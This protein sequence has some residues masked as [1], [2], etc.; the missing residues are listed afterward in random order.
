MLL[1]SNSLMSSDFFDCPEHASGASTADLSRSL[2]FTGASGEMPGKK[3]PRV[4]LHLGIE[5]MGHVVEPALLLA[6]SAGFFVALCYLRECGFHAVQIEQ[7]IFRAVHYENGARR[8]CRR[9]V[10]KVKVPVHSGD[11][12]AQPHTVDRVPPQ[13]RCKRRHPS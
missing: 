11:D 8:N 9:K 10:G 1:G 2:R 6:R 7:L 3:L 5:L 12:E 13:L 4:G